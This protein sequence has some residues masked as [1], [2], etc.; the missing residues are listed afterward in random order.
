MVSAWNVDEIDNVVLP[1]CHYGFQVYTEELSFD[2][3]VKYW[4]SSIGKSLYYAKRMTDIDLDERGV[5]KRKLSL[6]WNQRSCDTFLGIPFNISSYGTLLVLISKEVNMVPGEL[7]GNL[8]DVHL[9][10]NH[11]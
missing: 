4:V 9:Y 8:C 7:I 11:I 2:E 10:K 3:R 5:H 1:P 6:M